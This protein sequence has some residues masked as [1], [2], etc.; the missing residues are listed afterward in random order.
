MQD[1]GATEEQSLLEAKTQLLEL[2]AHVHQAITARRVHLIH[3]PV[4]MEPT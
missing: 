1:I 2:V 4:Q 3:M